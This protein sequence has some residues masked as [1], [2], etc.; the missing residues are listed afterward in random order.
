MSQDTEPSLSEYARLYGLTIDHLESDPLAALSLSHGLFNQF[1]DEDNLLNIDSIAEPIVNLDEKLLAGQEAA[2]LLGSITEVSRHNQSFSEITQLSPHRVRDMKIEIPILVTDHESD[3]RAFRELMVPDLAN[4]HLPLES[5][6]EEADEGPTWPSACQELPDRYMQIAREER[7]ELSIDVLRYLQVS[8]WHDIPLG[9]QLFFEGDNLSY[10][11]VRKAPKPNEWPIDLLPQPKTIDPVMTPLMPMSPIAT[12]YEPSSDTGRLEFLS[13]QSSPSDQELRVFDRTLF[14]ENTIA[15][16][17]GDLVAIARK[18][19][20]VLLESEKIG[21]IYSPLR[22]IEEPPSSPPLRKPSR[23]DAKAEVPLTPPHST[24][25]PPWKRKYVSFSEAIVEVIPE[26]PPPI[27]KPENISS[28]DLDRFFAESIAPVAVKAERSIEQEQLQEADT[29]HRVEVPTMDFSRPVA[30]WKAST[31]AAESANRSRSHKEMLSDMKTN[32]FSRHKW[33]SSGATELALKWM[34]FPAALGRVET[35][36]TIPDEGVT[37]E[38]LTQP[39][40]V[41][42]ATLIWKRDGLRV[43]DD[44]EDSDDEQLGSATLLDDDNIVSLLRKRK[45]ELEQ[46]YGGESQGIEDDERHKHLNKPVNHEAFRKIPRL[47]PRPRPEAPMPKQTVHDQGNQAQVFPDSFAGMNSL[48]NFISIRNKGTM[49][50]KLTAQ[51]P[52]HSKIRAQP[53]D[54]T[55]R[56]KATIVPVNVRQTLDAPRPLAFPTPHIRIPDHASAFVVSTAF[57]LKRTLIRQIKQLYPSV[58]IIERDFTLHTA[59][60]EQQSSPKPDEAILKSSTM[61]D[62]ADIILSPGTGLIVTTVQKIKQR[63]LPGKIATSTIRERVRRAT[64]RYERLVIIIS[65][66]PSEIPAIDVDNMMASRFNDKDGEALADFAAFCMAVDEECRPIIAAGTEEDLACWIVSAKIKY[67]I[68]DP[69]VRLLQEETLWEVFLRRAG[70]NA[71]AAQV[72]LSE[73]KLPDI[74]PSDTQGQLAAKEG[75][76]LSVFIRMSLAERLARFQ[77]LLGGSKVLKSISRVLDARW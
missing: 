25:P 33:P 34:P 9:T 66:D 45:M 61:A 76:G 56:Q 13:E 10:V 75:F 39:E 73:L 20:G 42:C 67:G 11:R 6:D 72:I 16:H 52:F 4:E 17:E 15:K 7:L 70:M 40:C 30:P 3:M 55:M 69:N 2:L 68:N 1:R 8:S 47:S 77:N 22:N 63:P 14:E 65:Y 18:A 44:L 54:I 23:E 5:L 12:P 60:Y 64:P 59:F 19:N 71:F 37:K 35:Y 43:F 62:E 21:D 36:E 46:V 51:Q 32:Y 49:N 29:I 26:L 48:D 57:L 53:L 41:D 58:E 74:D 38:F 28:E 24:Q 31:S 50:S 27:P